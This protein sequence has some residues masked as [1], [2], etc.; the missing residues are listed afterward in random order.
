MTLLQVTHRPVIA[1]HLAEAS[2]EANSLT[3]VSPAQPKK[4]AKESDWWSAT[5]IRQPLLKTPGG[6]L[7]PNVHG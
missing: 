2:F 1:D 3:D 7:L 6:R 5:G 4:G